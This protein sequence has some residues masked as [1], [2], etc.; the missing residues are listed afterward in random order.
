MVIIQIDIKRLKY[1]IET[2]RYV[3]SYIS[4]ALNFIGLKFCKAKIVRLFQQFIISMENNPVISVQVDI[5]ENRV[6]TS[7]ML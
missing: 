4:Y 6:Y 5:I 3:I 1:I 2:N 7:I